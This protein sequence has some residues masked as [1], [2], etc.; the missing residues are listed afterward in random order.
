MKI[1]FLGDSITAGAGAGSVENTYTARIEKLTGAEVLNYGV[2]GTRIARQTKPSEDPSFDRDFLQRSQTLDKSA[3]L[4]FVFG[5]TN[6]YGHGD[7]SIGET[8]DKT[9]YSFCGALNLL[10]NNLSKAYGTEK[11]WFILPVHRKNEDDPHGECGC[12]KIA[13]GTLNDYINAEISVLNKRGVKY[14]DL[15]DVF[16]ADRL[17]E[18]TAD[19]VHPNA[20]GHKLL[21]DAIVSRCG[22]AESKRADENFFQKEK[23]HRGEF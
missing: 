20:A 14:L 2:G 3:D 17:D 23:Q 10:V 13:A 15:R 8:A 12:K 11:L 16:P 5:G 19:G 6:D 4:V 9:P 22:L 1:I 18:L 7:A 21:A